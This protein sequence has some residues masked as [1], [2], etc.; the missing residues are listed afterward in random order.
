MRKILTILLAFTSLLSAANS[1]DTDHHSHEGHIHEK[2]I[3]GKKLEVDPDRFDKFL[4]GLVDAQ[5]AI[6]NV[7]GMVCDFC[8]RGI[9]KTFKIDEKVKKIDV[10]LGKG[11]VLIAYSLNEEID[12]NDIKEKIVM[13]GQNAIDMQVVS[14]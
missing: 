14:L 13:N 11:K 1:S 3:D 2:M 7:Q 10:D 6:V 8:A 9:E 4:V 12:F 5:V